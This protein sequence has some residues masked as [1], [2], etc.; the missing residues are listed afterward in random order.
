[1]GRVMNKERGTGPEGS[2]SLLLC[3]PTPTRSSSPF[4]RSIDR[5][6]RVLRRSL[7]TFLSSCEKREVSDGEQTRRDFVALILLSDWFDVLWMH[8]MPAIDSVEFSEESE[9]ESERGQDRESRAL[10]SQRL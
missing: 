10:T 9:R 1:M 6:Y 5:I 4:T 8:H 3:E 2:L 7:S